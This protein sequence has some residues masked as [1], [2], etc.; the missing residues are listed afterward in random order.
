MKPNNTDKFEAK[1]KNKIANNNF[2]LSEEASGIQYFQKNSTDSIRRLNDYDSNI[3]EKDAYKDV[4][5][6]LFKL[7]YKISSLEKE[8]NKVETQINL[9]LEIADKDS[10]IE[11]VN[12]KNVLTKEYNLY[13]NTY[14][15]K[16]ISAKISGKISSIFKEKILQRFKSLQKIISQ[17]NTIFINK[18]P[19]NIVSVI[20]LKK[21]IGKL[22]NL[23]D[24]VDGLMSSNI[25]YGENIN[26]YEQLSKYLIKSN[27]IQANLTKYI[28]KK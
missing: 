21:S 20:E 19:Q 7:E 11:L 24:T 2:F 3:L 9:A 17:F 14:K 25:P 23:N 27:S 1:E 5:D 13:L 22:K 12:H 6:E 16:S 18:L 8:L 15:E 10:L 28:N 26:K 4:E